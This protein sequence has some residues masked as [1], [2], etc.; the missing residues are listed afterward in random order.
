MTRGVGRDGHHN[1]PALEMVGVSKE[2][3]A[4]FSTVLAL[5]DITLSV[6][7]HE[8]LAVVGRS[9]CGKTTLLRILAG[10]TRPTRGQVLSRGEPLWPEDRRTNKTFGESAI[11]FQEANLFPWLN[12]MENIV[13][14]LMIRGMGAAERTTRANEL[15]RLVGL[16][17]FESCFPRELSGGMRQRAALARALCC[18]P[19]ILLMDEPFG[20]LDALTREK[21]N[22]EL[23]TLTAIS[24]M[25]V[26]FVTHSITEAV[27]M[28]DRVVLLSPRPGRLHC[29]T[30]I[31]FPRPRT[32]NLEREPHFRDLVIELRNR[33]N[34]DV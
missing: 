30:S 3:H 16:S 13:L 10:L 11:V 5:Q 19:S 25:T 17:G 24:R 26:V 29:V 23:Q 32:L 15:C 9:G 8:F 4:G 21:M 6:P 18:E 20:S 27:F 34:E 31:P 33:L 2:F 7:N 12:T 14:P 1:G 28:A 22:L